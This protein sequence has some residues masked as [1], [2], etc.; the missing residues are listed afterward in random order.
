M[1]VGQE[2]GKVC[3]KNSEFTKWDRERKVVTC[4]MYRNNFQLQFDEIW[5]LVFIY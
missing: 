3:R 4:V 5:S 1:N 2:G